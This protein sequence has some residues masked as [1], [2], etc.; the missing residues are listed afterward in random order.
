MYP[1]NDLYHPRPRQP[2]TS[3][4]LLTSSASASASGGSSYMPGRASTST[5]WS[6][7]AGTE[8]IKD[9]GA[10]TATVASEGGWRDEAPL[11]DL[12]DEADGETGMT[13]FETRQ[14]QDHDLAENA[15]LQQVGV[16]AGLGAEP[17][18][19]EKLRMLLRQMEAEVRST[20][21]TP[22]E[23]P[24]SALVESE[25]MSVAESSSSSS[26]RA[27]SHW[28]EGRRIGA[29]P[30][31]RDFSP[32]GSP[33]RRA[34]TPDRSA[35]G[36]RE[37]EVPIAHGS[38]EDDEDSP[39]TPPLRITNPYLYSSR[40]VSE[41]ELLTKEERWAKLTVGRETPTPPAQRL[42]SR[43]AVLHSSEYLMTVKQDAGLTSR[44]ISIT[45][46]AGKR[47]ATAHSPRNF[48][49]PV[50]CPPVRIIRYS[51]ITFAQRERA[52]IS[53]TFNISRPTQN[54][55]ATRSHT[56]ETVGRDRARRFCLVR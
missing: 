51:N 14:E 7:D 52:R 6:D 40:R 34:I 39:P 36:A 20:G 19:G 17:T 10:A 28:R 29:L 43:A 12:D 27:K 32:P 56:A 42:S 45:S 15:G 41:G 8:V 55:S 37:M 30:K 31:E 13:S 2:S 46:F 33:P 5:S 11:I 47:G 50:Q 35:F 16:G 48:H 26:N 38:D 53:F 23:R 44:H 24:V 49:C 22:V 9:D 25:Y 21:E 18:P 3:S 54:A 4:T 1:H